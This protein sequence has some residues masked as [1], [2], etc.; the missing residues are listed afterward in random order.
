[1]EG[2]LTNAEMGEKTAETAAG[3]VN[4]AGARTFNVLVSRSATGIDR[5]AVVQSASL[6]E[7]D[8]RQQPST[9]TATS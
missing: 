1:M 5:R 9:F 8:M 3:E 2:C 6:A 7:S 4:L